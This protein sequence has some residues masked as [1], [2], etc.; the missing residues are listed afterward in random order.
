MPGRSRRRGSS[1]AISST[2]TAKGPTRARSSSRW[3]PAH[4]GR[5]SGRSAISAAGRRWTPGPR[6]RGPRAGWRRSGYPGGLTAVTG[7]GD[8]S[9]AS[10]YPNC[11]SVFGLYD[12]EVAS[13]LA[14]LTY[15]VFGWYHDPGGDFLAKFV[16]GL[17]PRRRPAPPPDAELADAAAQSL[18][19]TVTLSGGR[20]FPTRM[21][22]RR[23]VSFAVPAARSRTPTSSTAA[24]PVAVGNPPGSRRLL[25]LAGAL[26][27]RGASADVED[28]LAAVELAR[29]F[30]DHRRLDV[31]R[32]SWPRGGMRAGSSRSRG[33]CSGSSGG[34]P[35]C[36]ARRPTRTPT[37]RAGGRPAG[38]GRRPPR[39]REHRAACPRPGDRPARNV[40][41]ADLRRLV[42]ADALRVPARRRARTTTP[43]STRSATSS[44]PATSRPCAPRPTRGRR[45]PA[46][47]RDASNT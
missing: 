43:T 38:G 8:P 30:L 37:P 46:G 24:R 35:A 34:R 4:R 44:T 22:L 41:A 20:P 29:P 2:P 33:A 19:W 1:R 39:R 28:Q 23:A 40:A 14:G 16:A 27:R 9:F 3:H 15:D 18:G 32:A 7:Y 21:S 10:F 6:R 25:G 12:G 5:A 31:E 36:S 47:H 26:D 17:H 13:N 11:L 45:S 42:Q